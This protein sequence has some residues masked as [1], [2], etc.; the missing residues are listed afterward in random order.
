MRSRITG[1]TM[2]LIL[3]QDIRTLVLFLLQIKPYLKGSLIYR[4]MRPS[5]ET[6]ALTLVQSII[7]CILF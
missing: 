6:N 4:L 2:C 7:L 3:L 5:K 1:N